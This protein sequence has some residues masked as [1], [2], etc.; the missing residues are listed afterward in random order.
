M[1]TAQDNSLNIGVLGDLHGHF[2][3][4]LT[5]L[6]RWENENRK[7]FDLILQ[8]GDFGV[9]PYP[10][11][12]LDKATLKFS[13]KDA[14]EISFP[15]YLQQS[16]ESFAFFDQASPPE[17][18]ISSQIIFIKGNHEDFEYLDEI[19]KQENSDLIPVDYY[20]KFL[21]LPNGASASIKIRNKKLTVGGIG[22]I[23]NGKNGF[24]KKEINK[25]MRP[26][27]LDVLLCHEPYLGA[28]NECSG[29][30][31]IRSLVAYA[32]P[33]Y[34]F[35]GHYHIEGQKLSQINQ[36]N[37]YILNQV[38]FRTERELSRNCIGILEWSSK[39]DNR[40]YFLK[41]AWLWKYSKEN[42]RHISKS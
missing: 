3:L 8:V 39:S 22:G 30:D 13:K 14:D 6:K 33:S 20:S 41:D 16:E 17:K 4:A 19:E 26:N 35:C 38:S 23:E 31:E 27:S 36:T 1:K 32:E 29:S 28:L 11:H 10:F 15:D 12:K 18:R 2:C 24:T 9:W 42:Y 7:R 5:I 21:Y 34:F 37:S 40:F 25:L